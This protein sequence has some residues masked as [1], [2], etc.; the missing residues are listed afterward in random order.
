MDGG[1][2]LAR[3]AWRRSRLAEGRSRAYAAAVDSQPAPSAR[4][5]PVRTTVAI[6]LLARPRVEINGREVPRPR[7]RKVWGI[8]ALLLLS[9]GPI[10]RGRLAS[11]LFADADDPLSA[12]RWRPG[13]SCAG[14][15]GRV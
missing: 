12:L 3:P 11:L 4:S 15:S 13:P 7:G 9:E 1:A 5:E 10:H 14:C 2:H 6:H 8:L